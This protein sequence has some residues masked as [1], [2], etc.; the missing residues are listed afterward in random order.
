MPVDAADA[1][2]ICSSSSKVI[3]TANST[4]RAIITIAPKTTI[5]FERLSNIVPYRLQI[6]HQT[7]VDLITIDEGALTT[8]TGKFSK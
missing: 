6:S 5:D 2:D 7:L 8:K 3:R 4:Q 1:M